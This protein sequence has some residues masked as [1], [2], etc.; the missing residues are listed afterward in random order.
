MLGL[1]RQESPAQFLLPLALLLKQMITTRSLDGDLATSG[2]SDSLF[3][4]AVRL[5]LGHSGEV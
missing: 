3:S 2:L 5:L 1:L 4:A